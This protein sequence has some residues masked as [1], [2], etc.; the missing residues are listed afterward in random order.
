MSLSLSLSAFLS[1][2]LSHK[3]THT[4]TISLS[5]FTQFFDLNYLFFF[6]NFWRHY[7]VSLKIMNAL[8]QS[9]LN[10]QGVRP[11]KRQRQLTEKNIYKAR[12]NVTELARFPPSY[13][14]RY[15]FCKVHSNVTELARDPPS[16]PNFII[17]KIESQENS[18]SFCFLFVSFGPVSSLKLDLNSLKSGFI[19]HFVKICARLLIPRFAFAC[20]E[21]WI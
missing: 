3:H 17:S 8:S 14:Q 10:R 19:M 15:Y 4:H 18:M 2:S 9:E 13:P 12:A 7:F 5:S 16:S 6:A 1:L 21:K 20:N 11:R